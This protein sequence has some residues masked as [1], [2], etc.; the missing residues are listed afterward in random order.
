MLLLALLWSFVIGTDVLA[1]GSGLG[2]MA[3]DKASK[4]KTD[5]TN[6]NN[7]LSNSDN[8]VQKALD[9]LDNLTSDITSVGD[10]TSGSCLDGTSTGGSYISVFQSTGQ[11]S[12]VYFD[13]DSY[14]SFDGSGMYLYVNGTLEQ[15]WPSVITVSY[16]LLETG[17]KILLE[18]GDKMI[19]E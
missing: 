9:T 13:S 19:L 16:A 8:T 15:Q 6:F 10:C 5:T 11:T 12:R 14:L 1:Q 17:S 4:I 2:T 7:K 18:T 3:V